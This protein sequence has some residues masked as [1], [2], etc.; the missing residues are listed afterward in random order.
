MRG[1]DW[2]HLAATAAI[3]ELFGMA[4]HFCTKNS[5][6]ELSYKYKD[7]QSKYVANQDKLMLFRKPMDAFDMFNPFIVPLWI[8]PDA[9]SV[10]DCWGD[11]KA[12]G[13]DIT[14]HW[15]Q[16]LLKHVCAHFFAYG[17]IN[18]YFFLLQLCLFY[19]I[20]VGINNRRPTWDES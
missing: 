14:K 8:D 1:Y 16:V 9:I 2:H 12:N 10:L 19:T 20:Y 5:E 18:N 7:I 6:G 4:K 13:I 15:S 17:L 11:R 3:P